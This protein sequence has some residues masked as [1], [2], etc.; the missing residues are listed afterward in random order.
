MGSRSAHTGS[1]AR[2]C[3]T[4]RSSRSGD[5]RLNLDTEQAPSARPPDGG[6]LWR[7]LAGGEQV[8]QGNDRGSEAA[9]LRL[10]EP[11]HP[12]DTTGRVA[13]PSPLVLPLH[14]RELRERDDGL[15]VVLVDGGELQPLAQVHEEEELPHAPILDRASWTVSTRC[16]SRDAVSGMDGRWPEVAGPA[17]ESCLSGVQQASVFDASGD[18]RYTFHPLPDGEDDR[19][20]FLVN[21]ILE[22]VMGEVGRWGL[23]NPTRNKRDLRQLRNAIDDEGSLHWI[24]SFNREDQNRLFRVL[25]Q[26]SARD[27]VQNGPQQ[28]PIAVQDWRRR[29]LDR[30][31][32][33]VFDLSP[34]VRYFY[35][36]PTEQR[37]RVA[38]PTNV[39]RRLPKCNRR[40][41]ASV[42]CWIGQVT[43][44]IEA[45]MPLLCLVVDPPL[46]LS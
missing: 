40:G 14:L 12:A 41:Q 26:E 11:P 37:D 45:R 2:W 5:V 21:L 10:G 44:W 9:G 25:D 6:G 27:Q 18:L 24:M 19:G 15:V 8:C 36:K 17:A 7:W 13:E 33:P 1:G 23:G 35:S 30:E 46:R 22:Q 28:L 32:C 20:T 38:I 31:R 16:C 42:P 29:H 43:G 3:G 4:N 34:L 39:R